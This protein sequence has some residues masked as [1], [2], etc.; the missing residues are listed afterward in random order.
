MA[1]LQVTDLTFSYKDSAELI[2]DHVSFRIDTDWKLGFIGR[3]G[4][5]KTTFLKLLMKEQEYGGTISLNTPVD[6][7][8]FK[9]LL[10]QL[11]TIDCL[12]CL[13]PELELWRMKKEMRALDVKEEVLYRPFESLSRGEQTKILLALLFLRDNHFLLIDEP[14]NHLDGPSRKLVGQYLKSKKGFILV[15]HDRVFLD[16]CVDHI[17]SINRSGIQVQKGNYSS[18]EE[19]RRRRDSYEQSENERLQKDIRR[20]KKASSQARK[21]ADA[22]ESV[23]IGRKGV[24]GQKDRANR[25]Y[26]GEKSRR[27]Q[28]RRKNLEQR[29]QK[30]LEEKKELLKDV[31][32]AEEL[33]L[34]P[35]THHQERL[36]SVR[37]LCIRCGDRKVCGPLQFEVC[38][39]DRLAINGRNGSGKSSL[40]RMILGEELEHSGQ[41][42]LASGLVIS[43]VSQDTSFLKGDLSERIRERGLEESLVKALLRKLDFSRE[44]FEKAVETY[45]EG[46]KKKVLLAF[47]LCCQ[48]H[49]YIWDEPLNYI[50]LYSRIQLEELILKWKPTMIFVEHD[51]RFMEKTATKQLQMS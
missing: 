43:Y 14:T 50:D 24:N 16:E 21:W 28:Q 51:R 7:F 27:M 18:W 2:F 17:L 20:L 40:I 44:Q 3:N 8:P 31:E 13:E 6:Y 48:A 26:I 45:S 32:R 4:R 23:K 12:Y 38:T 42:R 5:G 39:G 35:L 34:M 47:S 36:V 25:D 10:P 49:L 15:S 1:D 19:N 46:Q 9:V 22:A 29:Q 33:K 41:I 37:D 11:D 30:E